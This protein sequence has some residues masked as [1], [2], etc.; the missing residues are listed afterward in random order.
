MIYADTDFFLALLKKQDWLQVPARRLLERY[1]GQLR[2]SPI[3]LVELLLLAAEF[4]L[5]PE[6]LI[7]SVVELVELEEGDPAYYLVAARH[8]KQHKM[9]VFD[10]LHAAF[11]G[12][13]NTILSSDK[14]FDKLGL[15]RIRLEKG[16]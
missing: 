2:T 12:R 4:G 6:R 8:L 7:L 11:C 16:E 10:A 14:V 13:G 1:R 3:T 5:D 9:G 15:K